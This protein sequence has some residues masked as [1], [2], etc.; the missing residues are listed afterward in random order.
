MASKIAIRLHQREKRYQ[1]GQK[2]SGDV[3]VNTD[4]DWTCNALTVEL[5][6]R[7]DGYGRED[8]AICETVLLGKKSWKAGKEYRCAFAIKAP[9]GPETYTGELL[10]ISWYLSAEADIPWAPDPRTETR[11]EL[12]VDGALKCGAG[13]YQSG[14]LMDVWAADPTAAAQQIETAGMAMSGIALALLAMPALLFWVL[15]A[16]TEN[17]VHLYLGGCFS[18]GVIAGIAWIL[19]H[20]RA[21]ANS[22]FNLRMAAP[23][24]ARGEAMLVTI[25]G[26]PEDLARVQTGQA[27]LVCCESVRKDTGTGNPAKEFTLFTRTIPF[28]TNHPQ[29]LGADKSSIC[30]DLDVSADAAYSFMSSHNSVDWQ[31]EVILGMQGRR[32]WVQK[33]RLVVRPS[34]ANS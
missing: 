28:S 1:P 2:I 29:P 13:S 12:N 4:R 26:R 7:T 8:S 24:V 23:S 16:V 6:W 10:N 27:V 15:F 14:P 17:T 18:L 19:F 11:I 31:I 21:E 20:R 3:V 30:F 22:M 32:P 9:A 5:G 33:R 34:P 25:E